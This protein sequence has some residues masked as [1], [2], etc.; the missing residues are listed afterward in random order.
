[1]NV[2]RDPKLRSVARAT[3]QRVLDERHEKVREGATELAKQLADGLTHGPGNLIAGLW[4]LLPLPAF[5]K[6][7]K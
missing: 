4:G 1:M 5:L 2:I 3:L 6:G 7:G